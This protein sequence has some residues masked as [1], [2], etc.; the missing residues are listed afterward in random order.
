MLSKPTEVTLAKQKMV[1][2][3]RKKLGA[4]LKSISSGEAAPCEH[5]RENAGFPAPLP[6]TD[7]ELRGGG[8]VKEEVIQPEEPPRAAFVCEAVL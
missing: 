4:I 3:L 1:S 6:Q 5:R 2:R 8:V 7:S